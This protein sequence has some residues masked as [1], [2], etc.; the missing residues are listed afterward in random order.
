MSFQGFEFTPEMRKLV[1]NVKLFFDGIKS[2]ATG[3]KQPSSRLAASALGVSE[4]TVK[5]L[6]AAYNQEGER[7]SFK[8]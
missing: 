7:W 8:E 3:L 4:S 2:D 5:V 1:V 6:M